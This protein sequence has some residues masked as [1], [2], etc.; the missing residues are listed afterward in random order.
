MNVSMTASARTNHES[1]KESFRQR[2]HAGMRGCLTETW[3]EQNPTETSAESCKQHTLNNIL[4][5][6]SISYSILQSNTVGLNL[7]NG[8][9]VNMHGISSLESSL[10]TAYY[11]YRQQ[12]QQVREMHFLLWLHLSLQSCGADAARASCSLWQAA[13]RLVCWKW[14]SEKGI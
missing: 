12:Q 6:N 8:I 13:Q 14:G 5:K 10:Q 7:E 11:C 9:Y 2:A 4:I 3:D 1:T